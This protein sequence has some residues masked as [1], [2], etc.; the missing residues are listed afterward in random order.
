MN[1]CVDCA[2]CIEQ[3]P[4][5]EHTS[6]DGVF[7]KQMLLKERGTLVPQHAHVYDHTSMLARGSVRMWAD[8]EYV[9]DFVAPQPLFIKAKVKHRF[10]SLEPD[11][12]IYCIHN[13]SRT[14]QV[15]IH[16]EHQLT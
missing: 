13:V 9:G 2:L 11:T 16:A 5:W 15:E 14:G 6:V 1:A 8:G 10:Q 3:P 7:V 12:L 4:V